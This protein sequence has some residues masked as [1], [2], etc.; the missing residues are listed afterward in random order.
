MILDRWRS[1]MR[2]AREH[3]EL[4]ALA[5]QVEREAR[6]LNGLRPQDGHGDDDLRDVLRTA[7]L[8]LSRVAR[9]HEG[10]EVPQPAAD[11]QPAEPPAAAELPASPAADTLETAPPQRATSAERE[12]SRTVEELIAVRDMAL[13]AGDGDDAAAKAALAALDR[14][15][16]RILEGEGVRILDGDGAFDYRYQEVLDFRLTSDPEQDEAVCA[17]VRPGYAIGER[18]IR[19]QQVVV[20]RLEG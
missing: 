14:K 4:R 11:E 16:G 8:L 9:P 6:S 18:I 1:G 2:L 15:L 19:P 12:P 20:Y 13:V 17:T 7:S 10:A 3:D 5:A